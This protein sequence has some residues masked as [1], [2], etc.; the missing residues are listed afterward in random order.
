M[1]LSIVFKFSWVRLIIFFGILSAATVYASITPP[2]IDQHGRLVLP[3]HNP[4][5]KL[6]TNP[7]KYFK[8][9]KAY[10]YGAVLSIDGVGIADRSQGYTLY[11]NRAYNEIESVLAPGPE[12]RNR[13][14]ESIKERKDADEGYI[15]IAGQ[16]SKIGIQSKGDY[17]GYALF[18][19]I[20]KNSH[21][22]SQKAA[23]NAI[24]PEIKGYNRFRDEVS[25]QHGTSPQERNR[26]L[27]EY[28]R[29]QSQAQPSLGRPPYIFNPDYRRKVA[30]GE[31]WGEEANHTECESYTYSFFP[32][33]KICSS[34]EMPAWEQA[35]GNAEKYY[36][37][38][39]DHF[40]EVSDQ[41]Q[42]NLREAHNRIR[43]G[44]N[45]PDDFSLAGKIS[46]VGNGLFQAAGTIPDAFI[47]TIGADKAVGY[48]YQKY[49]SDDI[50][51][52]V[53][54][55][56]NTY[57]EWAKSHPE[58][59]EHLKLAGNTAATILGA[60]ATTGTINR[61]RA[62]KA[63]GTGNTRGKTGKI[64][65]NQRTTTQSTANSKTTTNNNKNN[66][67]PAT[68]HNT[69]ANR[70][71]PTGT[72]NHTAKS[73]PSNG[74]R[75]S[76]SNQPPRGDKPAGRAPVGNDF[77][78]AAAHRHGSQSAAKKGGNHS[79]DTP[80]LPPYRKPDTTTPRGTTAQG[81]G[82]TSFGKTQT[83]G[84]TKLGKEYFD[85][86]YGT[87]NV[88]QGGGNR[89]S[90]NERVRKNTANSSHASSKSN[91]NQHVDK[92]H[93]NNER[94]NGDD[95]TND[96]KISTNHTPET[97]S[98]ENQKRT[99]HN[100]KLKTTVQD[101]LSVTHGLS[102]DAQ[103]ELDGI[104]Q[105][106]IENKQDPNQISYINSNKRNGL[107]QISIATATVTHKDGTITHYLAVSGKSWSGHAPDKVTINGKEYQVIREE[108]YTGK[109]INGKAEKI[110]PD[111]INPENN[112]YNG[113]HA[114]KK[115]MSYITQQN[116]N[117]NIS[118]VKI[119]IQNTSESKQGACYGCGGE[120]AM[121]G[122]IGDF[123]AL[124][125]NIKIHIEHGSTQTSK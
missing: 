29:Q 50:K 80:A 93:N 55:I 103:K 19:V 95:I 20:D 12:W 31:F 74:T 5:P 13:W 43:A 23:F 118:R 52:T 70:T 72:A 67:A 124:N 27:N 49:T 92:T 34:S 7:D 108:A 18:G 16:L 90:V 81:K 101:N 102:Y 115:L 113:N 22:L 44:G 9:H 35:S 99:E 121:G 78:E 105:F 37:K 100:A 6:P 24:L 60:R 114:E 96:P 42:D 125:K 26:L 59:H 86:R 17:S 89:L 28:V 98:L 66:K 41:T 68:N 65:Q 39:D 109:V 56:G 21:Y 120:D 88:Q 57:Q 97:L 33:Q 69:Q 10:E 38:L 45:A 53:S 94:N 4:F 40:T 119:N 46:H 110:L 91:F 122:S 3:T 25:Q 71:T 8:K 76:A 77:A 83:A 123:K 14:A 30:D 106:L 75:G 36:R 79:T 117:G 61:G 1:K 54:N 82:N 107:S 2:Q 111:R 47:R 58:A 63:A 11:S 48:A 116:Q 87:S 84:N 73:N 51:Q 32:G 62:G 104:R 64:P 15:S 85:S 112:Q